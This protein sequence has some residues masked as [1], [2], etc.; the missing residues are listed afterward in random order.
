M[1][2]MNKLKDMAVRQLGAEEYEIVTQLMNGQI[3]RLEEALEIAEIDHAEV[4]R[5][6]AEKLETAVSEAGVDK[7]LEMVLKQFDERMKKLEASILLDKGVD[8]DQIKRFMS[9]E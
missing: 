2:G 7:T 1:L 4:K 9:N 3:E 6:D 8:D 5:F